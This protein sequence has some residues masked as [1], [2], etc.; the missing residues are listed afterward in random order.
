[1]V[2]NKKI[3]ILCT[4][5]IFDSQV[6]DYIEQVNERITQMDAVL[7]IFAVNADIYWKEDAIPAEAS[8]FDSIPYDL[9]DV[10]VIMDEKIKC[11]TVTEKIIANSK[12]YNLP[13]IVVDGDY[14]GVSAIVFDYK[15]G[16][17][18]V[19]RHVFEK[20]DIKRPHIMAGIPDN[21][22]SDERIDAFRNVISEYGFIFDESMVSYGLFWAVPAAGEAKRII[23]SGQIPDAI[24]C[25]NDIMA[26][27]VSKVFQQS[28]YSIPDDLV[29]TGFDGLDEVFMVSPKITTAACLT[30]SFSEATVN[31]IEGV[32][33]GT[34][35][36]DDV[37]CTRVLPALV[38]NESTGDPANEIDNDVLLSN[39][40]FSFYRHQDDIRMMYKIIMDMQV[41]S[42]PEEMVDRLNDRKLYDQDI[43]GNML[44]VLNK[45]CFRSDEYYFDSAE[46]K[47]DPKDLTVYVNMDEK[48]IIRQ[49]E[50]GRTIMSPDNEL[51]SEMVATGNPL[52]FNSLDY[53][54]IPIGYVC[55][56]YADCDN[57]RYTR[58]A[59]TTGTLGMGIGS[60]INM[61]YQK[62][63]VKQVN[64]YY[65]HDLLT[66][67]YN[68][69]GFNRFF[70]R[71]LEEKKNSGIPVTIIMY[72]LDGL[73]VI[74]DNFGHEEGDQ[75]ISALA[76][77]V[78]KSCPEDAFNVRFGGD[79]IFS[80]IIGEC[81]EAGI[82]KRIDDSLDAYNETSGKDY[83]VLASYGI[84]NTSFG[85]GF[86]IKE[87]LAI[88]D[89]HMYG[90][91]KAHHARYCQNVESMIMKEKKGTQ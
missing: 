53:M 65:E 73:K 52:I 91:K 10:V 14:E 16:F 2:G 88:A 57:T 33:N 37:I 13:V 76:A 66:G 78:K 35:T 64:D 6:H 18:N 24:F 80:V 7:L 69:N 4:S 81:D 84:C 59:S 9:A 87:A 15:T 36:S 74:N 86:D 45:N 60:Y 68:R 42:S 3:V 71:I 40:N 46:K 89:K 67:L 5:R 25:A 27:N 56:N 21:K 61:S 29:I 11:R 31:Y 83:R 70:D 48:R 55:Y 12:K 62:N 39:F 32:F 22:F 79:E 63:L 30:P 90:I 41:S 20:R 47:L 1:M 8:V 77:S 38:A 44:L 19:V 43:M 85:E 23:A 58:T 51:F 75:A 26:I 54:N 28:G 50:E 17:E 49:L 82:I 34:V 72:D